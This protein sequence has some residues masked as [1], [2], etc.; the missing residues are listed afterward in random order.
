MQRTRTSKPRSRRR[1]VDVTDLATGE[2]SAAPPRRQRRELTDEDAA[3]AKR[4]RDERA[5]LRRREVAFLEAVCPSLALDGE[6]VRY[7]KPRRLAESVTLD[8]TLLRVERV[9]GR[10][11][12][13][14][15]LVA[16]ARDYDGMGPNGGE[17]HRYVTLFAAFRD[18]SGRLVRTQG[19][20][21]HDAELRAV[22]LALLSEADRLDDAR[23]TR[24]GG[25]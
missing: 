5:E 21:V 25:P 24:E 14:S 19:V 17:P 6:E 3:D 12:P 7:V 22:A 20:A 2:V 9:S 4:V 13:G 10:G 23:R 1:V 16:V 18:G 8:G 15:S 11:L